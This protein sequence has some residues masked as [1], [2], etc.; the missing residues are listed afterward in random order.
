[1][2]IK[3]AQENGDHGDNMLIS[4]AFPFLSN[5]KMGIQTNHGPMGLYL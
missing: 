5:I 2:G 1:M 4:W 3:T